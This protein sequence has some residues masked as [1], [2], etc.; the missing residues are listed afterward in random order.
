[1]THASTP[2]GEQFELSASINGARQYAV[3]NQVGAALRRLSING[4]ELVQ[5]YPAAIAAPSCAGVVLVPWP[6]RVAGGKWKNQG[7]EEQLLI[8]EPKLNN[9]IHGLLRHHAY[10]RVASTDSSVTLA[11]TIAPAPGYPFELATTVHYQLLA[12][13]LSV[14]HRLQN[15]G[16]DT[17]PVAI[18]AHPYLRLGEVPIGELELEVNAEVRLGL[19]SSMIPT[20]EAIPVAGTAFDYR[21]GQL[22][23]QVALDDV[24]AQL[25]RDADGGSRHYLRAVDGRRVELRMDAN[26][27]F[28]QAYTT[29]SF[30]GTN[31]PVHAIA[32]EPMTAPA[33][34]FNSGQGLHQLQPGQVWEASWGIGYSSGGGAQ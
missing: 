8:T 27:G 20:G 3:V 25:I 13:G 15:L 31:G 16:T 28:L 26:F 29:A 1:M 5:D 14:T 9:A 30:P 18:G 22:L 10:S 21:E 24:W 34:A 11:A 19:D 32:L 33:N 17:A 2:M 12:D 7:R 23:G 6:N 4:M